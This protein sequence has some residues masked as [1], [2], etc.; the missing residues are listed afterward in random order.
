[1]GLLRLAALHSISANILP[2]AL[3]AL[4]DVMAV[5]DIRLRSANL[6]SCFQ[7]SASRSGIFRPS[8]LIEQ[9]HLSGPE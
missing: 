3:A 4:D 1:V 7:I 8:S 5:H 9:P 6:E 2:R